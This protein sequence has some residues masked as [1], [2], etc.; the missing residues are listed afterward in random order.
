MSE[1][2][3][4]T[5]WLDIPLQEQ[6]PHHYRLL[7]I[8]LYENDAAV[9]EAAADRQMAYVKTHA[10]G[11]HSALSQQLREFPVL[12][13]G[14]SLHVRHLPVGGRRRLQPAGQ[15]RICRNQWY[16]VFCVC[17]IRAAASPISSFRKIPPSHLAFFSLI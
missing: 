15:G 9:I 11:P 12:A 2:D 7:G 6:P 10:S 14:V 1:F 16:I 17:F 4:Y 13:R 8:G 3:P 5:V